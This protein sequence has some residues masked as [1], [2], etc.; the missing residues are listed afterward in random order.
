M[1]KI[2][3]KHKFKRHNSCVARKKYLVLIRAAGSL[4]VWPVYIIK[5][6]T[7]KQILN[8]KFIEI[9]TKKKKKSLMKLKHFVCVKATSTDKNP[10]TDSYLFFILLFLV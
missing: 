3:L 8:G 9:V 2:Y 10:T 7:C 6:L 1:Y 4:T 5:W